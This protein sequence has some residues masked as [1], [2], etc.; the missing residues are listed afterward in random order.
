M[1]PPRQI[2]SST[3]RTT[4]PRALRPE[5]RNS[6]CHPSPTPTNTPPTNNSA[7]SDPQRLTSSVQPPPPATAPN[8][9]PRHDPSHRQTDQSRP[10]PQTESHP[11]AEPTPTN[12]PAMAL[13][14]VRGSVAMSTGTASPAQGVQPPR[15]SSMPI[16][17]RSVPTSDRRPDGGQPERSPAQP[18]LSIPSV[19][20][21][22]GSTKTAPP[23]L[24]NPTRV[25]V[26]LTPAARQA[27]D[28]LAAEQNLNLT[29][30]INRALRLAAI[31]SDLAPE[32]RLRVIQPDDT[33]A[34][35]YLL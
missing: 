19:A 4:P 12:A 11:T 6:T 34:D 24:P 27:A 22:G 8:Q 25:T 3:R 7:D 9:L 23:R 31:V 17:G 15:S 33:I 14:Q 10:Q 28:K 1:L 32:N 13:P 16:S 26:N 20:N 30:A 35:I 21:P 5:R 18:A 2:P 29:D